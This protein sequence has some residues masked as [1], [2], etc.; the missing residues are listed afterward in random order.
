M[1]DDPDFSSDL[2]SDYEA[3][4][5]DCSKIRKQNKSYLDLFEK[6]MIKARLAY[7]TIEK[8]M[9]NLQL[10]L[11]DFLLQEEPLTMVDGLYHLDRFFDFFA[12]KCTW[13]SPGTVKTTAASIK[14]FYKS[15]LDHGHVNADQYEELCTEI[16]ERKEDW[17]EAT[18]PYD[19]DDGFEDW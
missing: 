5:K 12:R 7:S 11:D 2:G 17:M 10:F 6:D 14:K 13:S 4:E 15:M 3:Y 9:R 18:I 19:Q 16:K 1:S 8:H